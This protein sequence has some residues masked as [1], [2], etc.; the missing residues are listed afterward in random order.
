MKVDFMV[1]GEQVLKENRKMADMHRR[2]GTEPASL[3]PSKECTDFPFIH[4]MICIFSPFAGTS[5][6]YCINFHQIY[7]EV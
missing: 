1:P 2:Y 4:V 7:P 5:F 3:S 6:K